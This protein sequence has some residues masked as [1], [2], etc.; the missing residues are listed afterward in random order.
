MLAT[1][2]SEKKPNWIL[3]HDTRYVWLESENIKS[4]HT[5][6]LPSSS[7]YFLTISKHLGYSWWSTWS[8]VAAIV[9]TP[10][11]FTLLH[12]LHCFYTGLQ[13]VSHSIMYDS[14][15]IPWTAVHQASLSITSSGSLLKLMSI[16]SMMLSDHLIL[17]H[18]LLLLPS[19]FSSIGGFSNEL[20]FH[21][22]WPKYWS[23]SISPSN[24]YP[25][26]ISFRIDWFD[27][28]A[29]QG[30]LKSLLQHHSLK[31]SILQRSAFFM[32]TGK[33]NIA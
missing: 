10:C 31:A 23:L 8:N 27:L 4:S 33:K 19:I 5:N 16:E 14:L 17:R 9:F 18:P 30:I 20:A 26:L 28:L 15:Q 25:E 21:I 22:K 13:E 32:T 29:V 24:K 7:L 12:F 3:S 1:G 11:F 2:Y 6:F